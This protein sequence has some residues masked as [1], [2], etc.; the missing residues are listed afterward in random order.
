MSMHHKI[1]KLFKKIALVFF[2][3]FILLS[4]QAQ[5][6][7]IHKVKEG[8]TLK[9]IA[10]IYML[11]P[12]DILKYNSDIID[13]KLTT[14][15]SILIPKKAIAQTVTN[16]TI[17]QLPINLGQDVIDYKYHTVGENETLFGLSKMYN[18]KIEAITALNKIE[19]FDI[20]LGQILIIPIFA[21]KNK[22]KNIDEHKFTYYKVQPKQGKWRVAYDYGITIDELERLNPE[23]K[24][25]TLKAGQLLVVPK[26]IAIKQDTLNTNK[27]KYYEV[28]PHETMFSLAKRFGISQEELIRLNPSLSEG[29]KFG[30]TL[31]VPKGIPASKHESEDDW[32]NTY[33]VQA[34]ETLFSLSKRFNI[35]QDDL[36]KLN[37]E[38]KD[39]LKAGQILKISKKKSLNQ[40]KVTDTIAYQKIKSI[41][42][43]DSLRPDARYKVAILLPLKL[44]NANQ[45]DSISQC[46]KI[47]ESKIL[48]Y[49]SGIKMAIDSIKQLGIQVDYDVYD[50]Q[51]SSFV[52]G[53]ILETT[54]LSDYNFV[55]GPIKTDNIDKVAKVL[56]LDNTPVVVNKYKG[57]NKYRNMIVTSSQNN[58]LEQ[59]MIHYLNEK[60]VGKA[61]TIV[62]DPSKK[63]VVD[64]VA[65][66][67]QVKPQLIEAKE[68]KKG[69]MIYAD[70]LSKKMVS[71]KENYVIIVSDD[72]SFIFSVLSI[73]NAVANKQK[74][75]LFTLEDKKLYEDNS[76]DRM[77][78][79]LSNLN[80]HFPARVKRTIDV[81][82]AKR[83]KQT[84]NLPPSFIALNGFDTTFD[85]FVRAANADNLF[86]GMQRIGKTE[87]SSK[88]FLYKHTPQSGF[89]NQ[90]SVI[91]RINKNLDL[92][93]VE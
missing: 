43:L 79:F 68:T 35:S 2:L 7:S 90:G 44:K 4:V 71:G 38:L 45:S 20:K 48:D 19:G 30:Q 84:Y 13:G 91:L 78:A 33:E 49:Y 52:T 55:M 89:V 76:N 41:N 69:F 39:G 75:T 65:K 72:N 37:P 50:T 29:L 59:H 74:I 70:K 21:D 14:G 62:Y 10:K 15:Q 85:L 31:V 88:V 54:D 64:T 9:D 42:L 92:V 93:K 63:S 83:L 3:F 53:K 57:K 73:L 51:G 25:V 11:A 86:E 47:S 40:V 16:D 24:D 36:L 82:I 67:L 58:Y 1:N 23:I 77:N 61:L 8:E 6:F 87:Q 32:Y 5:D 80:Y 34:H 18:S 60:S 12:S 26:F 81:K 22:P 17:K 56:E 46:E 27:Y 66:Q 28:L